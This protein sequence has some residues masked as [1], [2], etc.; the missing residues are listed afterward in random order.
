[1]AQRFSSDE[2]ARI[3]AMRA[4]GASVDDTARRLG[5][6][7]STVYR[8]LE[9]GG[10]VYDAEA[11][12]TAAEARAAR[13]KTPALA[14][15]AGLAAAVSERL[16][17]RW[18]PHAIRADLRAQRRRI[19]A[20][21]IHAACY[22]HTGR[23]GLPE[24]SRRL[25]PRRWRRRKPRSRA[26]RKPSPLGDSKPVAARTAAVEDRREAGHCEGD[27]IIGEANRSAVATLTER[28]G[29]HTL[30]VALPDS[31]DAAST[32]AAAIAAPAR[33]PA[34]PAKTPTWDQDRET[35]RWA[36][37]EQALGAEA[38]FCDPH[39]PWQRGTNEHTNGLLR[40]RLPNS[41]DLDIGQARLAV[42]EDNLNSMPRKLHDWDSP[43]AVYT[44]LCRND[45]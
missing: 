45:R 18:S 26:T 8:E 25:P 21:T 1:M 7:R 14:A 37:T 22:D 42:I 29:R 20:E 40:R 28:A 44:A 5:R 39:P 2:R 32:A 13:P 43:Y 3:E 17:M 24:E 11:A 31:Y 38:Y 41:T 4:A 9:R 27:L 16:A 34:H 30:A 36:D 33:Q 10:G 23:R 15:D 19:S 35:A 6:H 12:Q